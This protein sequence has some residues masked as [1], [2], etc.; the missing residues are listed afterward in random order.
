MRGARFV[1]NFPGSEKAARFCAALL[2]PLMEHGVKMA[3]G[4][5]H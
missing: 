1:V 3:S 5:G 4:E 2:A